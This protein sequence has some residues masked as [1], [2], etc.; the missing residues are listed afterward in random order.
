MLT[1]P[2]LEKL[3][4]LRFDGM[5]AAWSEQRQKH[6]DLASLSFDERFGLLVD[7]EWLHRQ[8]KRLSRYLAEA[9]LRLSQACI[10]DIDYSA[11]RQLDKAQIRSLATCR[12]IEEHHN[13][14]VT[15][16]TGVG[17]TFIACALA[18]QACRKGYR[19]LYRR[20]SRLFDELALA[21]AD[22]SYARLLARIAR[23]DVFVLDDLGLVPIREPERRHLLEIMDDRHGSRSTI[24][25]SQLPVEK[26]HD[27]IGDPTIADAVCDRLLHNAHRLALKGPSRRKEDPAAN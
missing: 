12:W 23:T 25:T 6:G 13:V 18:Q 17:K 9:K 1:E 11:R 16:A 7:A 27:Y 15:G 21:Q 8:N 24:V 14:I 26:W 2:T 5:A 22:G 19:A 4:S 20:A 3:Q 10:E